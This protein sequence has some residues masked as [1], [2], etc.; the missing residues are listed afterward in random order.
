MLTFKTYMFIFML[1]S[2]IKVYQKFKAHHT[3]SSHKREP[4]ALNK[5][6]KPPPLF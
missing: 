2:K 6:E 5:S 3:P 1:Q 4:V